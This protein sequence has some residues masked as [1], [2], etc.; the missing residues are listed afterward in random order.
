MHKRSVIDYPPRTP[1]FEQA[2]LQHRAKRSKTTKKPR[3]YDNSDDEDNPSKG[4]KIINLTQ[5]PYDFRPPHTDFLRPSS[6]PRRYSDPSN[7]PRKPSVKVDVNESLKA[8]GYVPG[9]WVGR[10]LEDYFNWLK[11]Q[12]KGLNIQKAL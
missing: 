12:F 3:H 1:E 2:L 11:D 6:Y 10:G 8:I 7:S 9:D 5:Q 4:I